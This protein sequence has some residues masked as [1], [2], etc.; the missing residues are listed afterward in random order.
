MQ[1]GL[2]TRQLAQLARDLQTIAQDYP[3]RAKKHLQTEGN[4]VK[5]RLYAETKAST[6]KHSGNLLKGI[7][8]MGVKKRD[9]DMEVTVTSKAPHAHLIEEGHEQYAPVPGK[10]RK[11]QRKTGKRVAGRHPAD[12]TIQ[13]MGPELEKDASKLV[14]EVLRRG[15]IT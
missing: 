9:G 14:D 15:G 1:D 6:Q 7:R 11:Y 8:R 3:D 4:K 12:N 2:D 13:A 5:K 10:G